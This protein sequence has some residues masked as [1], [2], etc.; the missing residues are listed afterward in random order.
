MTY[1]IHHHSTVFHDEKPIMGKRECLGFRDQVDEEQRLRILA[2]LHEQLAHSPPP[3][4]KISG[5]LHDGYS[6]VAETTAPCGHALRVEVALFIDQEECEDGPPKP[7]PEPLNLV[8]NQVS[9]I[10][11]GL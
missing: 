6:Y 5:N 9:D 3:E 8:S 4:I 2:S 1:I 7:Q 11:R 10:V